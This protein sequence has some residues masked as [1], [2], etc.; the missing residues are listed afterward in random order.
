MESLRRIAQPLLATFALLCGAGL[1]HAQPF[2]SKPVRIVVPYAPGGSADTVARVIGERTSQE[3]KQ[4][5]LV[6]NKPGAGSTLGSLQVASAPADGYALLLNGVIAHVSAAFLIKGLTYDPVKSFAPAAQ[7]SIAP[8]VLVV[9]PSLKA[10]TVKE[11]IELARAEPGKLTFGSSGAGGGTHLSMEMLADATGMKLVHVPFKGT[12]P[13]VTALLGGHVSMVMGDVS[14]ASHVR[15]GTLRG[16]A[17]TTAQS[18]ALVSG[19]PTVS[20]AGVPGFEAASII[21]IL[22]PA[23]APGDV[24]AKINAAVNR[25]LGE[26]DVRQKLLGLGAEP[27][28]ATPEQ[29]GASLAAESQRY[30]RIIA[31]VGIKAD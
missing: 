14:V 27:A 26:E 21:G 4:P 22:A 25:A 1:A 15:S 5:V 13:A 8:F 31:R 11:L 23:K 7:I 19:V 3:W 30:G 2:P 20:Q 10:Q 9:S 16:L 6:D 17:V 29:F 24:I 28:P 12:A 18:S